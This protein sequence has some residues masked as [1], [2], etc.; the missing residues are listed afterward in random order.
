MSSELNFYEQGLVA[1][2]ERTEKATFH[3]VTR[4]KDLQRYFDLDPEELNEM[5]PNERADCIRQHRLITEAL[6]AYHKAR[7]GQDA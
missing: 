2:L 7:K 1:E 6:S 4:L 3:L 5:E